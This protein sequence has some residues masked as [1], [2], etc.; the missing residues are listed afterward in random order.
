M[1]VSIDRSLA[2]SYAAAPTGLRRTA[3][4]ATLALGAAVAP[5]GAAETADLLFVGGA[6]YTVDAAR[7]WASAVAVSDGRIIYVGDDAGART[8]AGASTRVVELGGKMLLPGFHDSHVHLASGGYELLLCDLNESKSADEVVARIERCAAERPG[9]G[10]LRGGGWELPIFP[11]GNPHKSVLDRIAPDRPV[12]MESSDGHTTWVNSQALALAGITAATPDPPNGRIERDPATG[13]PTGTLRETAGD[14]VEA[15]LPDPTP[16]EIRRGLELGIARAHRYG[17]V[18]ALEATAHRARL[19]AFRDLDRA[20]RLGMHVTAA[21]R[22]DPE[23]GPEQVAE[24]AALR[25]ADWGPHVRATAA[26][27]YVDGVLEAQ[28]GALYEPYVG[29]GGDRGELIWSE[30]RLREIAIALDRAGLQIHVHAIGDRAIGVTFDALEAVAAANGRRDRRPALTHIQLFAPGDVDRFREL[31][32]AASFQA[33]WAYEDAFIRDLTVPFLGP[34][35]SARLYPIGSVV[36]AGGIVA[37]GSDW[38][39]STI[40]PL[41]AIEVA[42]T[43][44]S[45]DAEAGPAWLPDERTDLPTM[46]AAYTIGSAWASFRERET[47]SIEAGKRADLVVL[48]RNLFDVP[49]AEISDAKVLL[50]LFGGDEVYRDPSFEV[51]HG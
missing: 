9:D 6:V 29:R 47:G 24:L 1:N 16:D 5:A 3:V 45:P 30:A 48:D 7:S 37:G 13:E 39:V 17:V 15:L 8:F 42:I 25:D 4:A 49:V 21:L 10:W 44:R 33:L 22:V 14:L 26:K 23:R 11:G 41:P 2:R 46:L 19:E 32:A 35:R 50:T 27:L 20:G 28:T 12:Y 43:R 34:E 31:G 36:R 40:N 51:P 38:S 18:G